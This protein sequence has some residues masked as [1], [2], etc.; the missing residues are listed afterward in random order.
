MSGHEK[1]SIGAKRSAGVAIR[2]ETLNHRFGERPLSRRFPLV[3]VTNQLGATNFGV[4]VECKDDPP[5]SAMPLN[6]V[7]GAF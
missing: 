6:P 4:T 1:P 2:Q 5:R 3:V 7:D